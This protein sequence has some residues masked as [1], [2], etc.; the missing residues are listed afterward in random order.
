MEISIFLRL[1][2]LAPT[3]SIFSSLE[4]IIFFLLTAQ[5]TESFEEQNK[6]KKTSKNAD[7]QGIKKVNLEEISQ[8]LNFTTVL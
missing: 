7:T 2:A 3:T 4:R 6:S 5:L 8:N 1:C